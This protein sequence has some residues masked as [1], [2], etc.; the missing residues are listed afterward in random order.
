MR[1]TF[2]ILLTCLSILGALEMSDTSQ[3]PKYLYK[4]LSIE[5]WND[6]CCKE[7][8]KLSQM[9]EEFIHLAKVD[10]ALAVAEKFWKGKD[11]MLLRIE[12]S[13]LDGD[14]VYENNP[15]RATKYYHLYNG[16][17]P[18]KAVD[19]VHKVERVSW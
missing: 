19:S 14:L 15:G 4:I 13:M 12:T 7:H 9:D 5:S 8:L 18:T 10:Q 16:S 6:S 17:I 11:Y 1:S 3:T 2:A